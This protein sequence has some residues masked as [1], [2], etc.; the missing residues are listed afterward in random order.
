MSAGPSMA[1]SS[2]VMFPSMWT[3][4]ETFQPW[5]RCAAQ[6]APVPSVARAPP[7]LAPSK[8]SGL[9]DRDCARLSRARDRRSIIPRPPL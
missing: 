2:N 7:P 3:L 6:V 9:I 5:P 1:A 8:F 4:G